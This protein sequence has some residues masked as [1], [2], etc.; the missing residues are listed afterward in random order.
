MSIETIRTI[1][2]GEP[3]MSTS[4]FIQFLSSSILTMML[5]VHRDHKDYCARAQDVHLD[6][7]TGPQPTLSSC[8]SFLFSAFY[9]ANRHFHRNTVQERHMKFETKHTWRGQSDGETSGERSGQAQ[10]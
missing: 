1:R 5:Y 7:Y 10:E 8:L 3:W 2:D 6:L 4:T 9:H